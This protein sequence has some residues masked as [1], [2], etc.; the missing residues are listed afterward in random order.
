MG[1]P[2]KTSLLKDTGKCARRQIIARLARHSDSPLLG[3]VFELPVATS[4][5]NK[6]PAIGLKLPQNL[7]DLCGHQTIPLSIKSGITPY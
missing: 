7:A 1:L 6:V 4:R 3:G 5:S 2:L